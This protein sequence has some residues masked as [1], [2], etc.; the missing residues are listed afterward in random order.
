[1]VGKHLIIMREIFEGDHNAVAAVVAAARKLKPFQGP[2]IKK[3]TKYS[4]CLIQNKDCLFQRILLSN[5]N[6]C[7]FT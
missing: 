3:V 7:L 4:G 2:L 6:P 5:E 1:M